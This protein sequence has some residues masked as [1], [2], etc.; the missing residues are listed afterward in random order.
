MIH[1]GLLIPCTSRNRPEWNDIRDTYLYKLS[2]ITFLTKQTREYTY[3]FYI[4]YDAD[5]RIF[6]SETQHAHIYRFNQAFPN[7][8][9]EFVKFED[10][11]RGHLT[12]MWNILFKRAYDNGK[13][14]DGLYTR[15]YQSSQHQF[16]ISSGK[17]HPKI[18]ICLRDTNACVRMRLLLFIGPVSPMSLFCF[19]VNTQSRT[20]SFVLNAISS[21][22]W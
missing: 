5:D 15:L 13:K 6:A 10:V 7:V 11:Q 14:C 9:F 21:P 22:H 20:Q 3:T 1:I 4:G 18:S 8:T 16:M 17:N 19:I 2:L 12:R